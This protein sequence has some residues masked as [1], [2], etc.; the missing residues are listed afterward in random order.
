MNELGLDAERNLSQSRDGG[1]DIDSMAGAWECK[2][3]ASLPT[4]LKPAENVR[5]V[6]FAEDNGERL[7]V[8]RRDDLLKLLKIQL[9]GILDRL[10]DGQGIA[11]RPGSPPEPLGGARIDENVADKSIVP[12]DNPARCGPT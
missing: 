2:K 5:G 10:E 11:L 9:M 8:I 4:Y 1:Y 6:F 12:D 3:R 7:C